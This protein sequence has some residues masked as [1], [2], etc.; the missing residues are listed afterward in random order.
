MCIRDRVVV[1]ERVFGTLDATGR[2]AH[3]RELAGILL[4]V[5]ALDRN[6]DLATVGQLDV[7]AAVEGD[8][9]VVLADLV[10]LGEVGVE[11]VLAR[12]TA[13][14]R[15]LAAEGEAQAC[16]LYTSRCV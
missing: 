2:A 14:R 16:L 13:R 4:H 11:V 3:V 6:R 8:R 9:L 7:D 1:D 15:D 12:E 5:G 10:V